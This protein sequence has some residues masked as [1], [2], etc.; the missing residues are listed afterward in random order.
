MSP[1]SLSA[2]GESSSQPCDIWA[3][4]VTLLV[5]LLGRHPEFIDQ[6]IDPEKEIALLKDVSDSCKDFIWHCLEV[7]ASKRFV[8][9][10]LLEHPWLGMNET[11]MRGSHDPYHIEI[12]P[13]DEL[14]IFKNIDKKP[15][16]NIFQLSIE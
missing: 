13:A 6:K 7:D 10:Q 3:L 11:D 14:N 8:A 12:S 5:M 9:A 2:G 1:E 4:G 15:K 16:V